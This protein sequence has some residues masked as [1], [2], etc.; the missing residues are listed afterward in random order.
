[1]SS[2]TLVNQGAINVLTGSGGART[3]TATLDNESTGTVTVSRS[4]TQTG[5]LAQRGLLTVASSQA[6]VITG[7]LTLHPGSISTVS[8]S[9]THGGCTDLGGSF[10]GFT[11]P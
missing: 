8:G 5:T 11:C 3:I 4:M 1:M 2:D 10:S 7:A 9:L 6:L